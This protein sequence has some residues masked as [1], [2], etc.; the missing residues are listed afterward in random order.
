[1]PGIDINAYLGATLWTNADASALA[2][3]RERARFD[4]IFVSS[5]L[6]VAADLEAGN[7]A[8]K[9]L[10]DGDE[11][12][13]GWVTVNPGLP[14]LS[15]E[16]MKKYLGSAKFAG[17]RIA[18]SQTLDGE[19]TRDLLNALRRY[20][21]PILMH[22]QN[23]Q[24]VRELANVAPD[25]NTLKFIAGGAGGED[26]QDCM[27]VARRITNIF[28]EP[29]T[30]GAQAGKLAAILQVLKPHRVLMGTG[31]PNQ[32]PG[33]ALGLL[34]DAAIS[35]ADKQTILTRSPERVFDLIL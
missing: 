21:K 14:E 30:G 6:A 32:N 35:D 20:S 26:W 10:V 12:V 22:V 27:L 15:G 9:A 2:H 29:F 19:P 4:K 7:A 33:V 17:V 31:Y 11:H 3:A 25:F 16:Q 8:V 34:G 28:L 13:R 18:T 24:Q 5:L 23:G 1:M